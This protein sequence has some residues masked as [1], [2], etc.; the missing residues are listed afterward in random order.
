MKLE[1]WERE[2]NY[3]GNDYSNYCIIYSK[4]RDSNI[5]ELS[6]YSA[7]K[8]ELECQNVKYIEERFN[9]WLCGY[10]D[11]LMIHE[12]YAE[13]IR[14]IEKYLSQ[15]EDYPILDDDDY[16][17][18][19]DEELEEIYHEIYPDHSLYWYYDKKQVKQLMLM[20][21]N[22]TRIKDLR[23]REIKAIIRELKD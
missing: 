1:R 3:F 13:D 18:R 10:V 5:L 21:F 17:R 4:N 15:L 7:I 23:K 2:T 8:E 11:V 22:K 16:Y 19:E 6:N 9:H 20:L 12:Q 14:S